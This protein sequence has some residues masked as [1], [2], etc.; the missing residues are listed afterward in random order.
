[1][2]QVEDVEGGQVVKFRFSF[3]SIGNLGNALIEDNPDY[4]VIGMS[5]VFDLPKVR[6]CQV[7]CFR[8]LIFWAFHGVHHVH[9][10]H[11]VHVFLDPKFPRW[12]FLGRNLTREAPDGTGWPGMADAE[13]L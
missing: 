4:Y 6:S 12:P 11:V 9:V 5:W 3:R 1:L 10:V 8:V 13:G 2:K 7:S